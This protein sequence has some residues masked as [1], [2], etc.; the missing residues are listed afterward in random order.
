MKRSRLWIGPTLGLLVALLVLPLMRTTLFAGFESKTVDARMRWSR[1]QQADDRIVV[2]AVDP[3]SINQLGRWPWPR[4]TV[5]ELVRRIHQGGA[6]VIA[7]DMIFS[8]PTRGDS[9]EDDA[10]A[11]AIRDAGNVVPGFFLRLQADLTKPPVLPSP[12]ESAI[13]PQAGFPGIRRYGGI[14]TQLPA[15]TE[16]APQ[17]GHFVAREDSDGTI[18]H[19][20]LVLS[21]D[22]ALYPALALRAVQ[23]QLGNP[24]IAVTPVQSVVPQLTLGEKS[25]PIDESGELWINWIAPWKAFKYVPAAAVLNGTADPSALRDKLVFVGFTETGLADSIT[26]P[27]DTAIPG[28]EVHAMVADNLL[29]HRFVRD[30]ALELAWSMV[31]TLLLGAL[32]GMSATWTRRPLMGALLGAL[33][34]SG[35]LVLA[36]QA[37]QFGARHLQLFL[38]LIAGAAAFTASTVWRNVFAE[39][40]AKQIRRVFS[41]YVSP[42]IVDEMLKDPDA[43]RLGGERRELTVLF[44]DIRGFTSL[45]ETMPPEQTVSLLQEYLTPM[46]QLIQAQGGTL[47]KYMGDGIMAFFGAPVAQ[48]D[49]APRAAAAAL[50]MRAALDDLNKGWDARGLPEIRCGIGLNSGPMAVGN[51]GSSMIFDYTVIGDNV[52]LGSRIEGLTRTYGVDVI[53]SATTAELLSESLVMR[54]LDA[55]RVKGRREPVQI[56][57]LTPPGELSQQFRAAYAEGLRLYRARRFA[58]ARVEFEAARGERPADLPCQLFIKRCRSY[59]LDPPDSDWDTVS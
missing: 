32:C 50:A 39:A 12:I 45:A 3:E 36:Q 51:I 35:Y 25:I 18:R 10:L 30:G 53:V 28:V 40:R 15:I 52:N 11:A 16:A 14:E 43:V 31:A 42:A 2:V 20:P 29:R 9:T 17:G 57:E 41:Q 56:F 8:E 1:G 54:E 27:W 21:Y 24:P 58:A 4:S 7:L 49:H 23:R 13:Q 22:D 44:A 38:P 59:E 37:F 19:Y 26:S 33:V 55:V 48:T 5:A 47:D 6:S 46:T 34:L